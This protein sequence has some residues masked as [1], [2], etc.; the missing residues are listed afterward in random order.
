MNCASA[1]ASLYDDDGKL[2][3]AAVSYAE[4]ARVSEAVNGENN[5]EALVLRAQLAT[6]RAR[7]GRLDEADQLFSATYRA[8]VQLPILHAGL[9]ASYADLLHQLHRDAEA[10]AVLDSIEPVLQKYPD[11][12]GSVEVAAAQLRKTIS[13][14]K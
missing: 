6:I 5:N 11:K 8:S 13:T 10:I 2:E 7:Q 9:G 14:G 1:L 4:A 12:M 3:L